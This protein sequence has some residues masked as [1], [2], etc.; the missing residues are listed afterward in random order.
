M[1]QLGNI[2]YR[3]EGDVAFAESYVTAYHEGALDHSWCRGLVMIGARYVNRLQ[4]RAG[5]WRFS[6]RTCVYEFPQNVTSGE[7]LP[8]P[9]E[10]MG[11]RDRSDLRYAV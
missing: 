7:V 1:H 8:L 9:P 6:D 4:K 3:I 11:R 5:E 2:S 10:S